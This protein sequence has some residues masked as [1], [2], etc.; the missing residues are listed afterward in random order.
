MK[1]LTILLTLFISFPV[2]ANWFPFGKAGAKTIWQNKGKCEASEG[3]KCY[4]ITGKPTQYH[5]IGYLPVIVDETADCSDALDCSSLALSCSSGGVPKWDQKSN[6]PNL[7]FSPRPSDNWFI[8]CE[9]E[10]LVIDVAAKNAFDAQKANETSEISLKEAKRQQRIID[11]DS[12]VEAVNNIKALTPQE[13]KDC[14]NVLIKEVYS[15][16]IPLSDL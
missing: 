14:L 12:C 4:D 7:D 5:K 15:K 11:K 1:Y 2:F 10:T 16:D 9:K 13:I 3:Q 6:W 8:W